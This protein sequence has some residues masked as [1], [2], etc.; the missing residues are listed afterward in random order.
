MVNSTRL[1]NKLQ[2]DDINSFYFQDKL[3]YQKLYNLSVYSKNKEIIRIS[4]IP[5]Y[6]NSL[7]PYSTE[8]STIEYF[9]NENHLIFIGE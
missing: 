8:S 2:R 4:A 9:I 5:V 6:P 7:Q 1:E 3:N